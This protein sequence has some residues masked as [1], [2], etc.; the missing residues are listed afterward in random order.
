MLEP[1]SSVRHSMRKRVSLVLLV[2]IYG[3]AWRAVLLLLLLLLGLDQ[4]A[5]VM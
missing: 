1:E 5:P 3:P 4:M 2:L